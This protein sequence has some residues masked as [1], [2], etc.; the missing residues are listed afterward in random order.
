ML[1]AYCSML[2]SCLSVPVPLHCCHCTAV[3]CVQR[4]ALGSHF[5]AHVVRLFQLPEPEYFDLEF[6]LPDGRQVR[7]PRPTLTLPD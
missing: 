7:A 4:H 3:C 5:Y 6:R 1:N 2:S